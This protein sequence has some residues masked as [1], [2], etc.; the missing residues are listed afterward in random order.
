MHYT[1]RCRNSHCIDPT[2]LELFP[3]LFFNSLIQW[4]IIFI[5]PD[6]DIYH[7]MINIFVYDI[8]YNNFNLR[9]CKKVFQM[10]FYIFWLD[11]YLL[12]SW[13]HWRHIVSRHQNQSAFVSSSL[14]TA[15][16]KS[17]IRLISQSASVY[18]FKV[19]FR[20]PNLYLEI[21]AKIK[22]LIVH[23][24]ILHFNGQQSLTIGFL[25]SIFKIFYIKYP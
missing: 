20:F 12:W 21:L 7:S 3:K 25:R 9:T 11:W 24:L 22:N 18:I 5:K 10:Y 8:L 13:W 23:D 1:N 14:K 6:I 4:S 16:L 17:N 15:H 2:T 19:I